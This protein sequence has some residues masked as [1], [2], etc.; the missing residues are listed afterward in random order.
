[1]QR[2]SPPPTLH[3]APSTT[4]AQDPFLIS[5][6]SRCL[7]LS[8]GGRVAGHVHQLSAEPREPRPPG[9][10]A[11]PSQE[12]CQHHDRTGF[13]QSLPRGVSLTY[14]PNT[15][16]P[17]STT[18]FPP[19]SSKPVASGSRVD[20]AVGQRF[21]QS[22]SSIRRASQSCL[23]GHGDTRLLERCLQVS[24]SKPCQVLV[25]RT[26]DGTSTLLL[27]QT[28]MHSSHRHTAPR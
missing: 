16:F 3:P 11:K 4:S 6:L 19:K 12:R 25:R 10:R 28:H 20:L 13:H 7:M 2:A 21:M 26:A 24:D 18:R 1:M 23:P 22:H 5:S 8:E 15:Y 17:A 9:C 27:G 14:K